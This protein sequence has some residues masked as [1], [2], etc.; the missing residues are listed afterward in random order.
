MA[1]RRVDGVRA[2]R[3]SSI[4]SHILFHSNKKTRD[5]LF[6]GS[7]KCMMTMLLRGCCFPAASSAAAASRGAVRSRVAAVSSSPSFSS[8]VTMRVP[9]ATTTTTS[10]SSSPS[11]FGFGQRVRFIRSN[12][13]QHVDPDLLSA[14]RAHEA[15]VETLSDKQKQSIENAK[16]RFRE[17]SKTGKKLPENV[18][19]KISIKTMS[20]RSTILPEWIGLHFRVHNGKEYIHFEVNERMVGHKLGEFSVTR[21]VG[22]IYKDKK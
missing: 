13:K 8:L 5:F 18:L 7:A 16:M 17:S 14:V 11:P 1:H 22:D 3:R 19:E 6:C 15:W 21:K 20:R 12:T 10:S 9:S 4:V 2:P